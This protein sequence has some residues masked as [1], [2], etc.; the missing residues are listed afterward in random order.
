MKKT[1]LNLRNRMVI[2]E[3]LK[4]VLLPAGENMVMY[5]EGFDDAAVATAVEFPCST[6]NVAGIR[7]ELYGNLYR[8]TQKSNDALLLELI[9]RVAA[10]EAKVAQLDIFDPLA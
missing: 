4:N 10:L 3:Y 7:K 5:K 6:N 1:V 2:A 8:P 9:D